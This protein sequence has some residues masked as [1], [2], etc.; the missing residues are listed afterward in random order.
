M[1]IK[2][3]NKQKSGCKVLSFLSQHCK[4]VNCLG[5]IQQSHMQQLG[6]QAKAAGHLGLRLIRLERLEMQKKKSYKTSFTSL[7]DYFSFCFAVIQY[8]LVYNTN[9]CIRAGRHLVVVSSTAPESNTILPLGCFIFNKHFLEKCYN[10][11][12]SQ[13]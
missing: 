11:I 4:K 9:H 12:I 6:R 7:L 8:V 3:W 13:Q 10:H 5:N 2:Y 1:L